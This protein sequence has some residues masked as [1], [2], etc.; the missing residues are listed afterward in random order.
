MADDGR[1]VYFGERSLL[2]YG[3]L[4]EFTVVPCDEVWS[5]PDEVDDAT[6]I[7][8]GIAG[9]GIVLPLEAAS[10]QPG[11]RLLVLGGT[12]ALGRLALQLGRHFGAGQIVAAARNEQALDEVVAAGMADASVALTGDGDGDKLRAASGGGGFDVVLDL[13]YGA[14]FEAALA[15]TRWGARLVT[16]GTLAGPVASVRAADML[17]RTHTTVGTGQRRAA[18]RRAVWMRLL[19][20]AADL[21]LCVPTSL[22]GLE[23][24]S[25]AWEHQ[26][27]SPHGKV[28]V[29]VSD[30]S[31]PDDR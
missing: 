25:K 11:D 7:L 8:M 23:E 12:G 24:G 13:V 26:A 27:A 30:P 31:G 18:E 4:A 10:L 14:P 21:D 6:A 28:L 3:A 19:D 20:L 5:V 22:Y 15:A 1:R 17:Y 29:R 9:T 16:V 2:P